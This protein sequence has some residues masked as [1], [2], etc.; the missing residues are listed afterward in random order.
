MTVPIQKRGK[1]I[2]G[3]AIGLSLACIA[4][5]AEL[6]APML[7]ANTSITG[8]AAAEAIRKPPLGE[9]PRMAEVRNLVRATY[10]ELFNASATAIP[11]LVTLLL[12]QDGTLYEEL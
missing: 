4:V 7:R 10:P 11:V 8:E 3:A 12:N 1:W 6:Q 5:A 9:D 2:F